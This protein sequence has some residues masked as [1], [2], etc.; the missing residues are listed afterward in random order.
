[1]KLPSDSILEIESKKIQNYLLNPDHPDGKSKAGFFL[2]NG[3][4]VENP[5]LLENLLKAQA[6]NEE[7]AKELATPFGKKFIFESA[8]EFPNRKTHH[9]RSVWIK[10]RNENVIK[11]VTAYKIS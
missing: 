10:N 7:V 4:T 8:I 11:F 9:I 1:M 5:S 2:L 6:M 3:I